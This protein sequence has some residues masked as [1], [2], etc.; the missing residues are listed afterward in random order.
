MYPAFPVI[1]LIIAG[2][3]FVAMTIYN[4]KL[5]VIYF[6]LVG[7]CYCVFKLFAKKS[8]NKVQL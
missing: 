4:F 2:V 7:I 1:A 3:S 8:V 5:A 6:L